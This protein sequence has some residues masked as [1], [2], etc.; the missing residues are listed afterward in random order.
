M[1]EHIRIYLKKTLVYKHWQARGQPKMAY[2]SWRRRM[3]ERSLQSL[4]K[5]WCEKG[6]S[7]TLRNNIWYGDI[8]RSIIMNIPPMMVCV[9]LMYNIGRRGWIHRGVR[10]FCARIPS[11]RVNTAHGMFA[12]TRIHLIRYA[13]QPKLK[14]L[15][16]RDH[17][18]IIIIWRDV[19]LFMS[20]C[21]LHILQLFTL[22]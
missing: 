11:P 8:I 6:L 7:T 1:F 2:I 16:K 13:A 19:N 18:F 4:K 9:I 15:L 17:L 5:Q 10:C 21:T 20:C 14:R 12:H 3:R 22:D